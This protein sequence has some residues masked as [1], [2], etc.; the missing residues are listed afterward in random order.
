MIKTKSDRKFSKEINSTNSNVTAVFQV[1]DGENFP[2]QST[3]IWNVATLTLRQSYHF[4]VGPAPN[5]S[6][7]SFTGPC[8]EVSFLPSL[9]PP[10]EMLYE[11]AERQAIELIYLSD[12]PQLPYDPTH[13]K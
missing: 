7:P 11:Y 4:A 5:T 3:D 6:V 12:T 1:V 9:M 13:I 2:S 8:P 10:V